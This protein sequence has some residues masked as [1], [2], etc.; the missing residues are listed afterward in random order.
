MGSITQLLRL[1]LA[2]NV[3]CA[4]LG[5]AE[6]PFPIL[7]PLPSEQLADF[8]P[9]PLNDGN[10][11]I[12]QDGLYIIPL[13]VS[14]PWTF[15]GKVMFSLSDEWLFRQNACYYQNGN[16]MGWRWSDTSAATFIF[17]KNPAEGRTWT[18]DGNTC[19][20]TSTRDHVTVPAG[21]YD[22]YRVLVRDSVPYYMWWANGK[23]I[24]KMQDT[25]GVGW[26]RELKIITLR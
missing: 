17:P 7:P 5:C 25:A 11:R 3:C 21:S 4:A 10:L 23:G 24:V 13:S 2:A 9:L 18:V 14:G 22:C 19:V 16:L 12:Y 6:A 8:V 15:Q 20:L 26:K 1:A